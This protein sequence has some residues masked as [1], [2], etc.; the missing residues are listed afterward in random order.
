MNISSIASSQL[1]TSMIRISTG[2][3]INSATD[4]AA[5]LAISES[6]G[7]QIRGLD[8]GTDNV[9][10]MQ[11]LVN[12]AE[13]G[14]DTISNNLQRI[15]ELAVQANNGILTEGNRQIIQTEIDQLLAEIDST[16]QRVEFNSMRLLDGGF[17][18][19]DNRYL[20]TA[21]DAAGRGPTV[22]LGNM[23][24]SMILGPDPIDVVQEPLDLSRVDNA[25]SRVNAQRS[26]LGAMSNRF[27]TTVANNQ[28]TNLNLA[29]ARSRIRDADIALEAM[30]MRQE[31]T[32][33]EARLAAQQRQQDDEGINIMSLIG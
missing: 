4:D 8:R 3:R 28:I 31:E 5:G 29:A 25:L 7:A 26:Y 27:D 19:T 11:N 17:S 21:G 2:Q 20:H 6:I 15:R 10:D 12:T 32:L 1:Q 22:V 16:T 9:L 24:S 13:G 33:Q 14:L 30:R 18:A 23:S